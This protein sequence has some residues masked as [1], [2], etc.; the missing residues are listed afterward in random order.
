MAAPALLPGD[1][2]G[3][4]ADGNVV[5][6]RPMGQAIVG[7]IISSDAMTSAAVLMGSPGGLGWSGPMSYSPAGSNA[8]FIS[9]SLS[10]LDP[11]T[12]GYDLYTGLPMMSGLGGGTRV[13]IPRP[14][15]AVAA[16]ER[17]GVSPALSRE[18][19]GR[20]GAPNNAMQGMLAGVIGA[21]TLRPILQP[22]L[23]IPYERMVA[24]ARMSAL[25][26]RQQLAGDVAA[27]ESHNAPIREVNE[28][29][30]A[31]LK[32]VSGEDRG[33]D[34][35]KWMDWVIDLQGYGLPLR[36]QS[37]P[38]ATVVEEVP[39]A[40]QPQAV[41]TPTSSV[42]GFRIGPSCFAGGTAVRTLR[43][44]RPIEEIRPGDQVLTQ[45]TTTGAFS[46]RPVVE[47]FHNPPNA[48]Y[49]VD[50]G[51][52]T[53]HPTGIHRFWKAGRGW[54]MARDLEPGDRLR[55]V[56]G[57]VEV[58][59]VKEEGPRPVFNLLLSGGDNYCVGSLGVVA[60]DNGFVDPVTAPFDGVP[61]TAELLAKARR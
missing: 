5:V 55:T 22:T 32:S 60:H 37:Q 41:P 24:E 36:A 34:R 14:G 6:S 58:A 42:V 45:D 8:P 30:A 43:G 51:S 26:A 2:V 29:A 56:G 44:D 4:D 10:Q 33:H 47:V 28:R 48:T 18:V 61:E 16:L 35:T 23:Q 12:L 17:A 31:I 1:R 25:V 11:S 7:N 3:T 19:V 20:I 46:Y 15:V 21:N 54:V 39:I 27:L 59:S 40:F 52:E 9:D 38:P 13:S 53:V 57:L 49:A 50:L